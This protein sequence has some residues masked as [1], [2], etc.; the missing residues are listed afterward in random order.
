MR[1]AKTVAL[2]LL[3]GAV[4]GVLYVRLA[5]SGPEW[6]VDPEAE[7]VTG[8]GRWLVADGGDAPAP[9]LDAAP[10]E[11]LAAFDAVA[12]GEGA[13]R[14]AWEPEAGRATYVD[15]SM[16]MGFP[17]YVS[18]KVSPEGEGSRL[19]AYSRLRF[20]QNDMGVN[21]DRLEAWIPATRARLE[22]G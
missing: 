18:V 10:A 11:V 1:I 2:V 21:R 8:P 15:R 19:A 5:P 20:G 16:V 9:R 4:A 14:L 17:D 13:E 22:A 6:H 3:A 7:G 12:L